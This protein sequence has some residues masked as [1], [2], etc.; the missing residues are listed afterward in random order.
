MET[1]SLIREWTLMDG[2]VQRWLGGGLPVPCHPIDRFTTR[3]DHSAAP[4][5]PAGAWLTRVQRVL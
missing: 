5:S 2:G 4:N 1:F 3:L